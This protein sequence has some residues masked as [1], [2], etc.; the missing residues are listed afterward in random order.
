MHA[1]SAVMVE[2]K[3]NE[4]GSR[5][6][7]RKMPQSLGQAIFLGIDLARCRPPTRSHYPFASFTRRGGEWIVEAG[8]RAGFPHS[9]STTD[10]I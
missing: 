8:R 2:L 3:L 6:A 10:A 7:G 9:R 1:A 5:W 4:R